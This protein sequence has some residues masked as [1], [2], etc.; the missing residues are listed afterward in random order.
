MVPILLDTVHTR[1]E[2]CYCTCQIT[3]LRE[4]WFH[5]V[6]VKERGVLESPGGTRQPTCRPLWQLL[7]G[8]DYFESKSN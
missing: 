2:R 4:L 8:M 6:P 1:V 3:V 5:A 7:P